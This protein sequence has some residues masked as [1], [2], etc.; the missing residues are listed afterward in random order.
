MSDEL[1][2]NPIAK[3]ETA[4]SKR[5]PERHICEILEIVET[6]RSLYLRGTIN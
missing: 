6:W 3:A 4:R 5:S 1:L 2:A